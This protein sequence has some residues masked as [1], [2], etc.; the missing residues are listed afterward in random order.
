MGVLFEING[1]ELQV[2]ATD[3]YRLAWRRVILENYK[4]NDISLIIPGKTLNELLRIIGSNEQIEVTVTQNQ[5]LF[6]SGNVW[7]ISRLIEGS[8]PKYKQVIPRIIF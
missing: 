1:S 3:T 5:I 6:V 2:V 8:F 4:E 7:L